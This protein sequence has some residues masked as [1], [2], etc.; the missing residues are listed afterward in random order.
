MQGTQLQ[1]IAARATYGVDFVDGVFVAAGNVSGDCAAE[2][3]LAPGRGRANIL[4]YQNQAIPATGPGQKLVNV[5][6]CSFDAFPH[7]AT[8]IGG[9]TVAVGDLNGAADGQ[10]FG[11]IIVGSGSGMAGR[12]RTFDASQPA[13]KFYAAVVDPS[14]FQQGLNVAAG[15]VNADGKVEIVSGAG[16][17]GHSW[18]RV[19][20]LD[21]ASKANTQILAFRAFTTQ[22][23][24]PN[25]APRVAVRDS[26]D[27]GESEIIAAQGQD[28]RSGYQIRRFHSLTA[29]AVDA[30][31][32]TSPDFF[33]G[34]VNLG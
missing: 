2:V 34:G 11:H 10:K 7:N 6:P 22:A 9:A 18:V 30:V 20:E 15:D 19:Y 8:F 24:V 31:F 21:A 14:G 27:D 17:G 29:A 5:T 28:G 1:A 33:G 12:I 3:I 25:A 26:D 4:V 16:T 13:I 32:A 23:D